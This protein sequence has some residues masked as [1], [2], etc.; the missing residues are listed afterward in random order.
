MQVLDVDKYSDPV[1]CLAQPYQPLSA[2][3]VVKE[4]QVN[5]LVLSRHIG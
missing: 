3:D 2:G 1:F 5:L 4:G